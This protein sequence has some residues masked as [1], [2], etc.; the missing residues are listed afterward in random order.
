M[1]VDREGRTPPCISLISWSSV[2]APSVLIEGNAQRWTCVACW[3]T[4]SCRDNCRGMQ[5]VPQRL[6]HNAKIEVVR[7]MTQNMAMAPIA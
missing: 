7:W 5:F 2:V 4:Y 1:F 3:E 6:L